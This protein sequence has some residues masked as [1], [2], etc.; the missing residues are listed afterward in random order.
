MTRIELEAEKKKEADAK[1]IRDAADAQRKKDTEAAEKAMAALKESATAGTFD[2]LTTLNKTF[3]KDTEEGQ[4]KAFKRNQ[5]LSIAETLVS[6]YAAAQKAYA[7]QLAIPS[8]DAPIRAHR[9]P[10]EWPSLRVWPRWPQSSRSS[11]A[12]ALLQAAQREAVASGGGGIQSVGVDVGTLVPES[13]EPHTGTR[14]RICCRERDIEQASLEQRA[15][16][17]DHAM[18]TVE[19]LID[20]EQDD[21][22]VEAISLVKFPAI[23]ENFVYFNKDQKLTLAKIDEDKQLLVG[24][25]LIPEKMIPRWDESKQEEFEVYFSKETVQQ[26]AELFMRQKRNGEYT[27]EH[28]TKVDGLSIFESWIVAD[29]DKDKAAVYGFDVP[30]GTWMVSVRVTN[31]D[32][33]ADVKDKK[34]RGFSIEGYFIDK[35]VKMEDVTIETIAAAVRDVL[36]PVAFLDGKP[37]FGTPLEARLMAEALG[38]EGHHAH[39]INGRALYMPCENHEQ[40]DPLLPNE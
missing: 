34:Y 27:V 10:P 23:E 18:R 7:S 11:L 40:L 33:W 6:T 12:G 29:K 26:A 35:L 21:F 2:L 15:A 8:P 38:C 5:A 32:V 13:A 39:E 3:A 24:P 20:E 14:P 9:L 28:Q 25:A 4:R 37:L 17:T 16:N 19:L 31:G 30:V 1:K 22:G 36:E